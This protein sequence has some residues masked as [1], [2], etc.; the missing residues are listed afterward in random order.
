[1]ELKLHVFEERRQRTIIVAIFRYPPEI[2][3]AS[4]S[5]CSPG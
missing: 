5:V 4:G 1:M 3:V 2:P